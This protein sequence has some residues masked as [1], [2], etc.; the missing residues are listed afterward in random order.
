[1]VYNLQ[2]SFH[3]RFK[4]NFTNETLII[5]GS[6]VLKIY[7]TSS[8]FHDS[9]TDRK[10]G[11]LNIIL[12]AWYKYLI[13]GGWGVKGL[14]Y[15]KLIWFGSCNVSTSFDLMPLFICCLSCFNGDRVVTFLSF[16]PGKSILSFPLI[17]GSSK[18]NL[19]DG[20]HASHDHIYV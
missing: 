16:G 8:F 2:N 7:S 14:G 17:M 3:S 9:I 6:R 5:M 20:S 1:M 19:F 11:S 10:V 15:L 13:I 18:T 4:Q 12:H